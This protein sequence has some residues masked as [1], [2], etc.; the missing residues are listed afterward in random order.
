MG[1]TEMMNFR[2]RSEDVPKL[3]AAAKAAGLTRSD[4]VRRAVTE[5][6]ARYTGERKPMEAAGTRG[7]AAPKQSSKGYPFPDCPKNP[8]C[9]FQKLPTGIKLCQTCGIKTS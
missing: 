8:A 2:L 3:D 1:K 6:V 5:L 4:F 7:P 9:K